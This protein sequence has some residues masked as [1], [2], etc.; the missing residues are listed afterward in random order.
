[1]LNRVL[2]GCVFDD[3]SSVNSKGSYLNKLVWS[4][5]TALNRVVLGCIFD[6]LS[7]VDNKGSNLTKLVWSAST[8]LNRVVLGCVFDDLISV[9]SKKS[10]LTKLA[11]FASTLLNRVVLG[12][13]FDDLISVD[14]KKSNLTK[15]E[16][17]A[18]TLLKQIMFETSN[19][20]TTLVAIQRQFCGGSTGAYI[21][22]FVV[23]V[24]LQRQV[25]KFQRHRKLLMFRKFTFKIVFL[26]LHP[27]AFEQRRVIVVWVEPGLHLELYQRA[28]SDNLRSP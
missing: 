28:V 3:L 27:D 17:F 7:S 6:D 8:V 13:V 5:S 11:W 14:S 23:P 21:D 4:A 24:V 16:W 15:L 26:P 18:S 22:N 10:N 25:P 1:M 19:V 9:D 12:C 20:P 2:L